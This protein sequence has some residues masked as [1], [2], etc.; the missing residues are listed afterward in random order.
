MGE[1]IK[2]L[3][4]NNTRIVKKYFSVRRKEVEKRDKHQ[5]FLNRYK[6]RIPKVNKVFSNDCLNINN[7]NALHEHW[8]VT[9]LL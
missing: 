2:K 4:K 9:K 5:Q 1:E 6:E 3:K 7:R 8:N